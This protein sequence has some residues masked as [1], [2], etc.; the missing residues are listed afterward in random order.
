MTIKVGRSVLKVSA[1]ANLD[2]KLIEL[3]GCSAR[4]MRAMID[5]PVTPV[6]LATALLPFVEGEIAR[7]DLGDRLGRAGDL[8]SIRN[9]VL[10]LYDRALA[11][12]AKG[13]K[14]AEDGGSDSKG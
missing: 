10:G 4:E 6:T 2:E 9:D 8:T 14:G 13:T 5:G 11:G 1:P 12:A 3:C 7:H